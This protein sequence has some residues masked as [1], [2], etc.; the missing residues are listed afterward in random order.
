MPAFYPGDLFHQHLCVERFLGAGAHGEVFAVRHLGTGEPF[1]LKMTP[2][3]GAASE[4]QVRRALAAARGAFSVDHPNVVKVYDLGCE[5]DGRVYLLMELL[6]GCSVAELLRWSRISVVMALSIAI[7]AARGLAAA[8]EMAVVH[9]DV[10]PGNLFLVSAGPRWTTVKVL[11][12]STAKVFHEGIETSTGRAGLGTVAY[13]A[14]EQLYGTV[15]HPVSDVYGLGMTLWEMLAGWHPFHAELPDP[16]A[17]RCKQRDEMPP[18]LSEVADL[19]PRIDDVVRRAIA[20][21]PGARYR[22]MTEMA[23][24]LIELRAWLLAES[25][26]GRLLLVTPAGEPAISGD[27]GRVD[28]LPPDDVAARLPLGTQSLAALVPE[29]DAIV[30]PATRKGEPR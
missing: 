3:A 12:F 1:A 13:Q 29:R 16:W 19:H 17:L 11:D 28:P 10:K 30:S 6:Q 26:A 4:A 15:P 7:E 27:A 21:H 24:A 22:A 18:L 9:R 5:P 2:L 25:R 20:K 14:P 8:H 23:Q